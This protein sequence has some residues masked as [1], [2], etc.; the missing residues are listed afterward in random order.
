MSSLLKNGNVPLST[1]FNLLAFSNFG[2]HFLRFVPD[3]IMTTGHSRPLA[4]WHVER[5]TFY[6]IISRRF[7]ELLQ[8]NLHLCSHLLS[9]YHLRKKGRKLAGTVVIMIPFEKKSVNGKSPSFL[10]SLSRRHIPYVRSRSASFHL[11]S[12]G[13]QLLY[14]FPSSFPILLGLLQ[15]RFIVYQIEEFP[16]QLGGL[17]VLVYLALAKWSREKINIRITS[18]SRLRNVLIAFTKLASFRF[19]GGLIS[20]TLSSQIFSTSSNW[21]ILSFSAWVAISVMDF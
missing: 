13:N 15:V 14:V 21:D 6:S 1:K 12:K 18:L 3:G 20:E 5:V 16:N 4:E 8:M 7:C 10:H 9:D 19:I 17:G 2:T 11:A